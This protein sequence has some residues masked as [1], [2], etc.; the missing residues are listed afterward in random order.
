VTRIAAV[1]NK[2][3]QRS[4][5]DGRSSRCL[6]EVSRLINLVFRGRLVQREGK[7]RSKSFTLRSLPGIFEE[8][9]NVEE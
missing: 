8:K 1:L 6:V 9:Q 4:H 5:F 7:I 2:N 3:V